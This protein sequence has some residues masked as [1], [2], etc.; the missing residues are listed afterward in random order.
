MRIVLEVESGEVT[1]SVQPAGGTGTPGQS[2]GQAVRPTSSG[3][4]VDAGP[5]PSMLAGARLG[6]AGKAEG[7]AAP[8]S[9]GMGASKPAG[10]QDAGPAPDLGRMA[11]KP[12]AG[13]SNMP[14]RT[15]APSREAGEN[16]ALNAGGAPTVKV[17]SA[18]SGKNGGKS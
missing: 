5:A 13:T 2:T 10:A 6:A 4:G 8:S 1:F 18:K 3:G 16:A 11:S 12:P 9:R 7:M 14:S 15:M 17:K